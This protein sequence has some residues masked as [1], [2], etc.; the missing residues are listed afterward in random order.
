M[1]RKIFQEESTE[2]ALGGVCVASKDE[3]RGEVR[4]G[5][6]KVQI[7]MKTSW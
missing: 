6:H 4:M 7:N 3:G 5:S 2:S 1:K